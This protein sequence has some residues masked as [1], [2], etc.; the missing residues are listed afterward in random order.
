MDKGNS[1]N[2]QPLLQVV[3]IKFLFTKVY[4]NKGTPLPK[5]TGL[6]DRCIT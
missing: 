2:L 3:H 6:A 1:V 5:E 4:K